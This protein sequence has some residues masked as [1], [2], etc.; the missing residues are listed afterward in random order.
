MR[1]V[2]DQSPTPSSQPLFL[3]STLLQQLRDQAGPASLVAGTDAGA[4]V[5]MKILVEEDEILPVRVALKLLRATVDRS[6]TV[7]AVQKDARETAGEFCRDLPQGHLLTRAGRAFYLVAVTQ[8]VM[9]LLQ[10][11]DEQIVDWEPDRP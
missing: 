1:R 10:R 2:C 9:K 3:F 6:P 8:V 7:R 4:V 11:L 5:T